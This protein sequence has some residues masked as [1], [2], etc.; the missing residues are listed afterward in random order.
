MDADPPAQFDRGRA[1]SSP[2]LDFDR[3]ASELIAGFQAEQVVETSAEAHR[4]FGGAAIRPS[5]DCPLDSA[6]IVPVSLRMRMG[7]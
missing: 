4:L 1:E 7:W 6:T 5:A 3:F 2:F